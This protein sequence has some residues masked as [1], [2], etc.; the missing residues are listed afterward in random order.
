MDK[1]GWHEARFLSVSHF[2]LNPESSPKDDFEREAVKAVLSNKKPYERFYFDVKGK[3]YLR[4]ATGV[5]ITTKKCLICHSNKKVGELIGIISYS[6]PL[7]K[8]IQ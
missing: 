7:E 8:Y 4:A 3:N 1:E 2:P 5:P 6:F